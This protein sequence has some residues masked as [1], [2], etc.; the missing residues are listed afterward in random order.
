MIHKDLLLGQI[1]HEGQR[2]PY[3]YAYGNGLVSDCFGIMT[4]SLR[5]LALNESTYLGFGYIYLAQA[6]IPHF[7]HDGYPIRLMAWDGSQWVNPMGVEFVVPSSRITKLP[8]YAEEAWFTL[9]GDFVFDTED[10]VWELR[11][12]HF[13]FVD[14]WR[15]LVFDRISLPYTRVTKLSEIG[16]DPSGWLATGSR[17]GLGLYIPKDTLWAQAHEEN[18]SLSQSIWF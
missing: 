2:V 9:F 17:E 13:A 1:L 18:S 6:F 16:D 11:Y 14:A 3:G 4:K 5:N 7:H 15:G 10:E 8:I 12:N